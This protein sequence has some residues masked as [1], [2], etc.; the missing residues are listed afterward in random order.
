MDEEEEEFDGAS[1]QLT[2]GNERRAT[3]AETRVKHPCRIYVGRTGTGCFLEGNDPLPGD[4]GLAWLL[5]RLAHLEV[6]AS[7][8]YFTAAQAFDLYESMPSGDVWAEMRTKLLVI[9]FS[10]IVDADNFCARCNDLPLSDALRLR[11]RLGILNLWDPRISLKSGVLR[12]SRKDDRLV[13]KTILALAGGSSAPAFANGQF[14]DAEDPLVLGGWAP[15]D[16]KEWAEMDP[17]DMSE[18][19][20]PTRG[21]LTFSASA[22]PGPSGESF[23]DL[24]G[25]GRE[26]PAGAVFLV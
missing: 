3:V 26:R 1:I 21:T 7:T 17:A 24:V 13:A 6:I 2:D 19:K 22:D 16:E 14:R 10:R 15:P 20:L 12:L 23:L 8:T 5:V 11:H 9:L 18:T 25:C 4:Y